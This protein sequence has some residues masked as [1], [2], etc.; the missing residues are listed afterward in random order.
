MHPGTAGPGWVS[1]WVELAAASAG[2]S[3]WIISDSIWSIFWAV[4]RAASRADSGDPRRLATLL[5]MHYELA[6]G[7]AWRMVDAFLRHI[8]AI[9]R[10]PQIV[11][12]EGLPA[13]TELDLR[14]AYLWDQFELALDLRNLLHEEH[15]EFGSEA[16]RGLIERSIH[17]SITWRR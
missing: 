12:G 1:I 6:D 11:T 15:L 2:A 13:Y 16:H 9:R 4:S 7:E 14:T 3:P 17:A 5:E 8:S 10:D